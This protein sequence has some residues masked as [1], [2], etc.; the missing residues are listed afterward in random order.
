MTSPVADFASAAAAASAAISSADEKLRSSPL[1]NLKCA[2]VDITGTCGR[3]RGEVDDVRGMF[4]FH[5]AHIQAQDLP[6]LPVAT[7]KS[8]HGPVAQSAKAAA[9]RENLSLSCERRLEEVATTE[10][11]LNIHT[12]NNKCFRFTGTSGLQQKQLRSCGC[13]RRCTA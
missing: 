13:S 8:K 2:I 9:Y 4:I 1:S 3:P 7:N 12:A 5:V 10:V 11:L 6:P